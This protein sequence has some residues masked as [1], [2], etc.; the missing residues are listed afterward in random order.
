MKERRNHVRPA[1]ATLTL[2]LLMAAVPAFSRNDAKNAPAAPPLWIQHSMRVPMPARL[3]T[4]TSTRKSSRPRH[5]TR[6][7]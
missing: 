7:R 6:R 1:G 5:T 2:F 3:A 4:K